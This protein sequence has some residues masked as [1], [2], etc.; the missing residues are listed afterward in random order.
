MRRKLHGPGNVRRGAP[1]IN[2]VPG[3][4][5]RRESGGMQQDAQTFALGLFARSAQVRGEDVL[6]EV[7]GLFPAEG[8]GDKLGNPCRAVAAETLPIVD[9]ESEGDGE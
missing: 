7:R 5:F 1:Q 9:L 6:R 8:P 3:C 4:E 2:H